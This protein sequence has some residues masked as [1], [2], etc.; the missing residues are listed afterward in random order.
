MRDPQLSSLLE[1]ISCKRIIY[2]IDN[3]AAGREVRQ[4][5]QAGPVIRISAYRCRVDND[6]NIFVVSQILVRNAAFFAASCCDQ[7]LGST[8]V[9]GRFSRCKRS[10]SIAQDQDLLAGK[11]DV[12]GFCG[13][14]EALVVS[15][16]AA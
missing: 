12:S 2:H 1:Q 10:S 3:T 9:A 4:G 14:Q 15:V 13:V 6:F 11:I 16:G 5:N 8:A 7:D